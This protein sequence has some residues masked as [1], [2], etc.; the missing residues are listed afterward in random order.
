LR[1]EASPTW[2]QLGVE[3][4]TESRSVSV[5]RESETCLR[6][7]ND[8]LEGLV[9]IT[10]AYKKREILTTE[11]KIWARQ[12]PASALYREIETSLFEKQNNFYSD[13]Y[14]TH[15]TEQ[16]FWG[17]L[18]NEVCFK[19]SGQ[20]WSNRQKWLVTPKAAAKQ[21]LLFNKP[22]YVFQTSCFCSAKS[23]FFGFF[24]TITN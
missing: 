16:L 13:V 15:D 14:W 6:K 22:A 18:N 17:M 5:N 3:V 19:Q 9:P 10:S 7:E 24:Y 21:E 1:G 8:D 2:L 4:K 23:F 20:V 11:P 12:F